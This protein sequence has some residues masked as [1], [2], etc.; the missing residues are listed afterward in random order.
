SGPFYSYSWA[1]QDG[2]IVAGQTGLFPVVDIAAVYALTVLNQQNGCTAS[3][4]ALVT[5]DLNVPTA[6]DVLVT[7]P[8]CFGDPGSISVVEVFGGDSP[9]LYSIDG[10]ESFFS[11]PD[12][13]YLPSGDYNLVI[14]DSEGC[15]YED[16]VFIPY[17]HE[18]GVSVIPE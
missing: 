13:Y 18:I 4:E 11:F 8:E 2:N 17:V 5:E 1:T 9:Y 14:Q 16:A 15:L 3:A 12:F 7:P 10:G 6:V